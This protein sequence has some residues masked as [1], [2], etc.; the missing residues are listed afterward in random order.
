[1]KSTRVK[2]AVLAAAAVVVSLIAAA[3][4]FNLFIGWKVETEARADLEYSLNLSETPG[5]GRSPNYFI[6]DSDF[7]IT[8]SDLISSTADEEKLAEWFSKNPEEGV[9]KRVDLGTSTCYA[10]LEPYAE[11]DPQY[12]YAY[13]GTLGEYTKAQ[14]LDSIADISLPRYFI[15][16]IDISSEQSLIASVNTAFVIIALVGALIAAGAGYVAG[17]RIDEA[18]AAQKRFYENMSHELKTPL[19]AIRG[20]A[21]GAGAGIVDAGEATRAIERE[22]GRMT[23]M[24]DEILG[25]S[26]LEAGVVAPRTEPVEVGDFVQDCL[27]PLEGTVRTAGVD[28]QLDLAAGTVEADPDLF[29]HALSNVLVNAV[30]HASGHVRVRFDGAQLSIWNGGSAPPADELPRLFD[31]FHVGE[32]GSTGIG[33]AIAKEVATLHGWTIT[34][35]AVDGVLEI[36]FHF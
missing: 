26:R 35:R 6:V 34:A 8:Q 27:M 28:V 15:A 4:A 18:Q 5:M 36:A 20:Y 23:E 25:L 19:A 3:I 24:I 12:D 21:E 14:G 33:L 16:Y 2:L 31:R 22:T 9:V 7:S 13:Y 17:R 32:G 11:L 1:M 10:A 30:R 29:E